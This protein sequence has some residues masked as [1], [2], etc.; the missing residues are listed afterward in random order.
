MAFGKVSYI[1]FEI[2]LL[3][4]AYFPLLKKALKIAP[5]KSAALIL[6]NVGELMCGAKRDICF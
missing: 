4:L 3:V 2:S 6:L 5:S 1:A